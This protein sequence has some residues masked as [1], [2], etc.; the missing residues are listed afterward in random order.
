MTRPYSTEPA[1]PAIE[2]DV[3]ALPRI[4][5]LLRELPALDERYRTAAELYVVGQGAVSLTEAVVMA[6]LRPFWG[7]KRTLELLNTLLVE[8]KETAK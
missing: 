7:R 2:P 8:I 6:G 3:W 4:V 5:G 1:I